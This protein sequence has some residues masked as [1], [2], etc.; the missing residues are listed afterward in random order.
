MLTAAPSNTQAPYIRAGFTKGDDG[1]D[2]AGG[3]DRQQTP[4]SGRERSP[5]ADNGKRSKAAR[6]GRPGPVGRYERHIPLD[7]RVADWLAGWLVT[8]ADQYRIRVEPTDA[9]AYLEAMR[10]FRWRRFRFWLATIYPRVRSFLLAALGPR[11]SR[12]EVAK[13]D[14]ACNRC[15][16]MRQRLPARPGGKVERF[17]G[18]CGC[19]DWPWAELDTKNTL[20]K[21]DCKLGLHE[22]PADWEAELVERLELQRQAAAAPAGPDASKALATLLRGNAASNQAGKNDG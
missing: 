2:D 17:C 9:A 7:L 5:T 15:K 1:A 18:A 16:V 21:A 14:T 13:R 20:G 11:M 4:H 3:P 10:G 8:P 6:P 19:P 12:A 22:R